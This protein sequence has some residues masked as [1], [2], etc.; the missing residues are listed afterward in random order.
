MPSRWLVFASLSSISWL[1]Y[2]LFLFL[3]FTLQIKSPLLLLSPSYSP[4]SLNNTPRPQTQ[5]S[6]LIGILTRPDL[7]DRRHFLRL[8]YGI[9]SSPIA[10]SILTLEILR[11]H[12]IIIL[13]CTENMNSGK[14]YTYFSSLT[15]I[16]PRSYDYVMKAD[17]GVFVRLVP[18]ASS[19]GPQTDMYYGFV[20]PCT[21]QNPFVDYISGIGFLFLCSTNFISSIPANHTY[22]PE[23][24]TVGKWLKMGNKGK[25][26]FSNKPAMYDY[27]GTNGKCSHELISETIAVH[28][29]KK[30]DQWLHVLT[31][32]NVTE[33]LKPSNMYHL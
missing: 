8:F 20:I 2:F 26:R 22:G 21:S 29:L 13:N 17:D 28:R 1:L 18:L 14:T 5:F 12:D 3:L 33:T 15:H 27:P 4:I 32:F 9:Q 24:K 23:D 30:W 10:D 11:F 19:L 31:F 6:L 16:L 25:N 7:Y